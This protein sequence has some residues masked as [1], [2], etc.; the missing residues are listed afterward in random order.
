MGISRG[1]LL[2]RWGSAGGNSGSMGDTVTG[3]ELVKEWHWGTYGGHQ[4]R[5]RWMNPQ[6][7]RWTAVA[8]FQRDRG[9]KWPKWDDSK[10]SMIHRSQGRQ[11]STTVTLTISVETK[12]DACKA[13]DE[14]LITTV[15]D[16]LENRVGVRRRSSK[17]WLDDWNKDTDKV[18][19]KHEVDPCLILFQAVLEDIIDRGRRGS[20]VVKPHRHS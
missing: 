8:G 11:W 14:M 17:G 18:G 1:W 15:G 9:Q 6:Q 10:G 4:R 20:M 19:R 7:R 2:Q 13:F 12:T 3:Q 16:W 5:L